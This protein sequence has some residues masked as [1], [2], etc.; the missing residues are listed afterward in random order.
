MF[1]LYHQRSGWLQNYLIYRLK[2][3]YS[4]DKRYD[5]LKKYNSLSE[6]FDKNLYSI[7][8]ENG[9]IFGCPIISLS[10]TKLANKLKFP[11]KKGGTVL[12]FLETL[13]SIAIVENKI[14]F[15]KYNNIYSANYEKNFLKIIFLVIDY[16][17]PRS[18]FR[19]PKDLEHQ[20]LLKN[21]DPMKRA[22]KKLEIVFLDY[23]TTK[24]YSP[25]KTR[26]NHFAFLKLYFFLLWARENSKNNFSNP[27]SFHK[28]DSKLR[29]EMIFMFS[30]LIWADNLLDNSEKYIIEK[31]V[32]QTCLPKRNQIEILQRISL[33][34]KLENIQCTFKSSIINSY[35]VEQVIL[36]SLIHNKKVWKEKKFIQDISGYL[37]LSEKKLEQ[38]FCSVAEFLSTQYKCL[39]FLNNNNTEVQKF[40]NFINDMVLSLVRKNL[41]KIINEIS[42]TKELSQLLLKSTS[43]QLTTEEKKKVREQ[44]L[45]I[46]RSI[47]ALA[48]FA[49][50]G[51]GLLLPV[52]IKVLPFR[53]LPSSFQDD[54]NSSQI[55]EK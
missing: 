30:A 53:I 35:L 51:G 27:S 55:I 1:S 10:L 46:A 13:F 42:E 41:D 16:Y 45:D 6:N 31:Y 8:K 38:L 47:P 29:E 21:N 26:Q 39:E 48:I 7:T 37:G 32:K 5:E 43:K 3:P 36:L 23:I 52:F 18:Y 15:E 44:L 22:L 54:L 20:E 40:Q 49:L 24:G 50:P 33:P 19:I 9:I 12:L 14:L 34:V 2:T 11:P 25:L 4:K 28:I 17:L